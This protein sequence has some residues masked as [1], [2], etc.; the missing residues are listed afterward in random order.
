[1]AVYQISY[2]YDDPNT[3][4]IDLLPGDDG[5]QVEWRTEINRNIGST[6]IIENVVQSTLRYITFDCYFRESAF[7]KLE[8]FMSFAQQGQS[9]SFTKDSGKAPTTI[10]LTSAAAAGATL[11]NVDTDAS[12][13]LSSGDYLYVANTYGTNWDIVEIDTVNPTN[14]TLNDPILH[15]YTATDCTMSWYYAFNGLYLM[16]DSF[17]PKQNGTFWNHEFNCVEVRLWP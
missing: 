11:L 7:H 14:I 9:F 12:T 6:G 15:A 1:M 5:V 16:D 4:T 10:G 8:T 2:V 17:N 3:A 13:F